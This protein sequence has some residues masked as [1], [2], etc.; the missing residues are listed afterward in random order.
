MKVNDTVLIRPT[1]REWYEAK[2]YAIDD[3][4]YVKYIDVDG[5]PKRFSFLYEGYKHDKQVR[6]IS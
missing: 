2:V 4:V 1:G 6:L 5:T 3:E